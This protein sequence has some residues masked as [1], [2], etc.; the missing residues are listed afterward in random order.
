ML[1]ID[2]DGRDRY[3]CETMLIENKGW[4]IDWA[5]DVKEATEKLAIKPYHAVLLDQV[6][7]FIKVNTPDKID[8]NKP[9]PWGGCAV[10]CWICK[11]ELPSGIGVNEQYE[12]L[13][14]SEP[15]PEN[16]NL[17]VMVISAYSEDAISEHMKL[18]ST[19][20]K[21]VN[22]LPK[23]ISIDDLINFV[24]TAKEISDKR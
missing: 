1:W 7:P 4:S 15:L 19:I 2:D 22:F 5:S 16:E 23:P 21:N 13:S 18:A 3:I 17:P 14:I 9:N 20:D 10:L 6:L 11:V 24:D 8:E 12:D